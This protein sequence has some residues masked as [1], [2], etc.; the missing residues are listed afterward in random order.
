VVDPAELRAPADERALAVD[1]V[2]EH[3]VLVVALRE[4][5]TSRLKLNS[6]TKKEWITSLERRWYSMS[7]FVGSTSTGISVDEPTVRISSP[8]SAF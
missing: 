1:G 7:R 6:G 5:D 8:L 4:G 2:L 3:A